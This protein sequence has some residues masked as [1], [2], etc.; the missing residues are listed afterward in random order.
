MGMD[1]LTD[2]IYKG[3]IQV[4]SFD[5][6]PTGI[7][8]PGLVSVGGVVYENKFINSTWTWTPL[9]GISLTDVDTLLDGKYNN[10][11][12]DEVLTLQQMHAL[13]FMPHET[14][15]RVNPLN[16]QD[17]SNIKDLENFVTNIVNSL[18]PT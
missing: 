6:L 17:I 18:M 4:P 9:S 13:P 3:P 15:L 12:M 7:T 16:D 1:V 10:L 8:F 5:S 2:L 11:T 14:L